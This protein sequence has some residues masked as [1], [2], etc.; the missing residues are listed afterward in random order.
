MMSGDELLANAGRLVPHVAAE[1]THLLTG[2]FVDVSPATNRTSASIFTAHFRTS[3]RST[4]TPTTSSRR[5]H[6]QFAKR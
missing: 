6:W 3:H 2:G 4:S 5:S 1:A